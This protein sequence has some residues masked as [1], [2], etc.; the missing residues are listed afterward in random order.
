MLLFI[1]VVAGFSLLA[2]YA[3]YSIIKDL[4][5]PNRYVNIQN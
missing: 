3:A 2:L 1:I 4:V 5:S